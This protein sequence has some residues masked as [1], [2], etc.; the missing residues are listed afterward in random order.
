[1]HPPYWRQ[2]VY[3]DDPRCLSNA[4]TIEAFQ[5]QFGAVLANC[6]TVL[7]PDGV[8][9]ILM[10]NYSHA[11]RI[12]PLTYYTME[13]AIAEGLWPC[14]TEIVRLQYRNSSSQKTY[15]SSFIPGVHDT[16]MVFRQDR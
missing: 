14:C 9:S 12:M 8:I 5:E 1:M 16:C 3:N 6:K 11:G 7:T 15:R 4:P 13:V 10:G 2:I